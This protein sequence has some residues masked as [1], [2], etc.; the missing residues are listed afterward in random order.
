VDSL[1]LDRREKLADRMVTVE[2]FVEFSRWSVKNEV[3]HYVD[4]RRPEISLVG[5]Q[6]EMIAT[7]SRSEIGSS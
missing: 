7:F 5:F 3:R 6:V 1:E 2:N 4:L